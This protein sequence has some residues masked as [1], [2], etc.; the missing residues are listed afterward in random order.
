MCR[1][2]LGL[3][4]GVDVLEVMGAFNDRDYT[5]IRIHTLA[6]EVAQELIEKEV[7]YK[8]LEISRREKIWNSSRFAWSSEKGLSI[9]QS[10]GAA[11]TVL[12]VPNL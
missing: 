4:E 1:F 6:K 10:V 12:I 11:P 3:F 5:I 7:V 8:F 2:L 9:S